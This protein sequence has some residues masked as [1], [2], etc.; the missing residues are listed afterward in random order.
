MF[1]RKRL[2]TIR[3]MESNMGI[4]RGELVNPV[5]LTSDDFKPTNPSFY[6]EFNSKTGQYQFSEKK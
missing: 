6:V 5:V 4:Y 1:H 2:N 3:K